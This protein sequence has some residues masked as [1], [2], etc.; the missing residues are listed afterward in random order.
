MI[1]HILAAL[2]VSGLLASGAH[3]QSVPAMSRQVTLAGPAG[4]NWAL[5][6]KADVANGTLT[7]PNIAGGTQS[8]P[9]IS[10]PS[11]SSPA[12]TGGSLSNTDTSSGL[13]TAAEATT[14]RS[15]ASHFSDRYNVRDFGAKCDGNTDDAVAI[16]LALKTA[17]L[18]G[19][20]GSVY[21]PGNATCRFGMTL[22]VPTNVSLVGAGLHS[23]VLE[24]ISVSFSPQI[25]AAGSD[26]KLRDFQLISGTSA[27]GYPSGG[28]VAISLSTTSAQ[29]M[30]QIDRVWIDGPCIGVDMAG[31]NNEVRGAYL[32]F[33]TGGAGCAGIRVGDLTT[34]A[35]T[36][37]PKVVDTTVA[38]DQSATGRP[39]ADMLVNDAG[40][41]TVDGNDLL[42]GKRGTILKPGANQIIS[43]VFGNNTV[44]G[45]TN[46]AGGLLIDTSDSTG[47]V[48]GVEC[49]T[50]WTSNAG[51]PGVEIDNTGSLVNGV[52]TKGT[53]AGVRLHYHRA[54][55]NGADGV[56]VDSSVVDF[57]MDHSHLC[58]NSGTGSGIL[59]NS[60]A[61][62]FRLLYNVIASSCD[63]QTSNSQVG[64]NL[65]G[66]NAE[67]EVIGNDL[68]GIA[69]P[70]ELGGT[71]TSPGA[72]M[73]IKDNIP[74]ST[75]LFSVADAASI[76]LPQ[77]YEGYGVTGSGTTVSN[78][79][80]AWQGRHVTLLSGVSLTFATGGT[81]GSAICNAFTST[82]NVPI[83]ASY[84]GCWYLK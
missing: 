63:G 29:F 14:G 80:S 49:T 71:N 32:N 83:D 53:I 68:T 30:N 27:L 34:Q 35:G 41:L 7:S 67:A 10:T 61:K 57:E 55:T 70:I 8:A 9:S 59:M 45:D 64:I 77:G 69:S 20:G 42:Y 84:Y 44:L 52:Q 60:G 46:S 13:A 40:G 3:A 62:R 43:W 33:V 38:T 82:P 5:S 56:D 25:S 11:I 47:K 66:N 16:N 36:T 24:P 4:L 39:D 6:T 76:D 21:L 75:E 23:S 2:A 19:V 31:N 17:S 73:I 50:C 78:L 28:S 37:D 1:R 81:S 74:V 22:I 54:Y 58:G 26:T 12:I 48:Q 51:G 65:G 79:T 18:S 72:Q 15:H